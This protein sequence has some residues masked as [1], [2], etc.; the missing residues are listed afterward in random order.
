MGNERE[1]FV[2][3]YCRLIILSVTRISLY[4]WRNALNYV[5]NTE[6]EKNE[7]T[8]RLPTTRNFQGDTWSFVSA[9]S[10][11][12]GNRITWLLIKNVRQSR[13]SW[14]RWSTLWEGGT[15]TSSPNKDVGNLT[16][17]QLFQ[18]CWS[19]SLGSAADCCCCLN[20]S[21]WAWLLQWRQ[22][23][24]TKDIHNDSHYLTKIDLGRS[25]ARQSPFYTERR[26]TNVGVLDIFFPSPFLQRVGCAVSRE[27]CQIRTHEPLVF[28]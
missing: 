14:R 7:K 5:L 25:P 9:G 2:F 17:R 6:F 22:R 10:C 11:C 20:L 12:Q 27:A 8:V 23:Q 24:W 13:G 15:S 26:L 19:D 28:M 18:G 3:V 16:I 21:I 1:G 4:N